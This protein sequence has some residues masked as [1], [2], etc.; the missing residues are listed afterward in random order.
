MYFA[1]DKVHSH[2]R[3]YGR[4]VVG[5][6]RGDDLLERRDYIVLRDDYLTVI[7]ADEIGCLARVFQV[8][9]ILTHADRKGADR[10]FEKLLRDR[11]YERGVKS[12]G[13]KKSERRVRVESF[14]DSRDKLVVYAFADRVKIAGD[15]LRNLGHIAVADE[16]AVRIVMSGRERDNTLAQSDEVFRLGCEHDAAVVG[17]SVEKRADSD[18]IARRDERFLRPVVDDAREFRIKLFEHSDTV[19]F[20]HRQNDLAVGVG[21]EIVFLR[22]L[23][24]YRAEAVYFAVAYGIASVK[25]KRLH[26]FV[27]KPH[28][29]KPV[30]A[31]DRSVKLPDTRHIRTA[32]HR[33][34]KVFPEFFELQLLAEITHNSTHKMYRL[35]ENKNTQLRPL[36]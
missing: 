24:L 15:I 5:A 26:A 4:Y 3:A 25:L 8:D 28:Y 21:C 30:K 12:A 7:A 32:R 19:L 31:E 33:F 13:E 36:L 29:R 23:R 14:L 34:F 10:L 9:R 16:F 1:A 6:E 22:Q 17:V 11:A 2:R 35:S 27:G 18:R 20:I